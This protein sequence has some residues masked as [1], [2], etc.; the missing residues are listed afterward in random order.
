MAEH[1]EQHYYVPPPSPWP[2]VGSLGILSLASGFILLL[3]KVA[4]GPYVMVL[5]AAILIYMLYGWFGNVIREDRA[6]KL[7][8]Q[9]D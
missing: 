2:I 4:A 9:V 3:A 8:G 1:A 5:G 7:E 6:G